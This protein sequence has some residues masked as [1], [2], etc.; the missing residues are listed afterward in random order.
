MYQAVPVRSKAM[1]VHAVHGAPWTGSLHE[2]LSI[3]AWAVYGVLVA[4][5]FGARLFRVGLLLTGARPKLR[6]ILR[7]SRLGA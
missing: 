1:W 3:A 5:R 7:Q 2:T 4:L 6:E